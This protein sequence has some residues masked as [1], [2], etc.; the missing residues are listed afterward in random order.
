M[1][2]SDLEADPPRRRHFSDR[3]DG[4]AAPGAGM[5][6]APAARHEVDDGSAGFRGG[7]G[8]ARGLGYGSSN[9]RGQ[10]GDAD[11]FDSYRRMR[12][13]GYHDLIVRNAAGKGGR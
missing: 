11:V 3:Q 1:S 2:F 6:A 8:G 4:A 13:S 12:S 9:G 10:E 7:G 5:H